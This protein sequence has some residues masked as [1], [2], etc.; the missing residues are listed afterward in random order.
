MTDTVQL[1]RIAGKKSDL[2][3]DFASMD[4]FNKDMF[5][6]CCF[7]PMVLDTRQR[8][9]LKQSTG[10][11]F[12]VLYSTYRMEPTVYLTKCLIL[13]LFWL[14]LLLMVTWRRS[15]FCHPP[16]TCSC[17]DHDD[18]VCVSCTKTSNITT[19]SIDPFICLP[20]CF[21]AFVSM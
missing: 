7:L 8:A 13:E 14:S 9:Y 18:N 11:V 6:P 16:K 2:Q 17:D 4:W 1:V 3:T 5:L 10:L 20:A 19:E 15:W 21:P 12:Y